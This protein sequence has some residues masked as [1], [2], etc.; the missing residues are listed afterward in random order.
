M[1]RMTYDRLQ[2]RLLASNL[3]CTVLRAP[4]VD[5]TLARI[6]R[7]RIHAVFGGRVRCLMDVS[8]RKKIGLHEESTPRIISD[9]KKLLERWEK[10]KRE[11][12]QP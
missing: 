6:A 1:H 7:D 4:F 9:T 2:L 11:K 8:I 10:T 5:V 12:H 3:Q